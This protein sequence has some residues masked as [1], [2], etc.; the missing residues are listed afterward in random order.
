MDKETGCLTSCFYKIGSETATFSE[1]KRK[2][3]R[4]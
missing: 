4:K 3:S 1:V 2:Y